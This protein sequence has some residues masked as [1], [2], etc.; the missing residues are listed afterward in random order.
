MPG[1]GPGPESAGLESAGPESAGIVARVVTSGWEHGRSGR[2]CLG[3]ELPEFRNEEA[4][5]PGV[6]RFGGE[7]VAGEERAPWG[8]P[9]DGETG[10]QAEGSVEEGDRGAGEDCLEGFA[11]GNLK[12][13]D[14][15]E[16]A[17]G[18]RGL[19]AREQRL[20]LRIGEAIEKKVGDD[21]VVRAGGRMEG[22]S[23]GVGG[24][25]A[26]LRT[27][28]S[29]AA[30]EEAQHGGAGVDG[31]GMQEGMGGE[32]AREE[33]AVAVAEDESAAGIGECGEKEEAAALE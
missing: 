6:G 18:K 3:G 24:G 22:A 19:N 25:E 26:V 33:A 20:D 10:E 30:G 14:E 29:D 21:E 31:V 17:G 23:V 16:R 7:A 15:P 27:L 1:R 32:E 28:K 12:F 5:E 11:G 4:S 9:A 2:G 13:R 8:N